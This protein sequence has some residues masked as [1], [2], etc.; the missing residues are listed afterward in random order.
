[1]YGYTKGEASH[2]MGRAAERPELLRV[3]VS[4]DANI[5]RPDRAALPRQS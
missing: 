3:K 5:T 4:P 1:M 2:A